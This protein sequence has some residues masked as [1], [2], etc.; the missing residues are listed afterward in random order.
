VP[1]D[2]G[3]PFSSAQSDTRTYNE[4][5]KDVSL[6][7]DLRRQIEGEAALALTATLLFQR[8]DADKAALLL[9][10]IKVSVEQEWNSHER[11]LWLEVLPEHLSQFT[12]EILDRIREVCTEGSNRCG[13]GI[14]WVGVREVLPDVGPQWRDQIKQF[15]SREK[16]PTNHARRVR[17]GAV[18][19]SEDWLAFTNNGELIVYQALKQ[20]QEKDLPPENTIG[21]YPLAGGRVPGRTWEPDFLITYKGRAGILEVDGPSHNGRRAL[22]Q[23]RD[24]LLYDAGVAFIDRVP[25]EAL[26]DPAELISTLKRFLRRL[27]ENR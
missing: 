9:D 27:V 5:L 6:A 22:D 10:V 18:Q 19:H 12:D 23:T 7:P 25:V 4:I 20:I 8:G 16:R 3:S 2:Y 21:I 26:S 17:A 14:D 13:Y 24:H 11:D 1:T 15:A